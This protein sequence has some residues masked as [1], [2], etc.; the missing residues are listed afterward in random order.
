MKEADGC[1]LLL[2]RFT[3]AGY[4][5]A[6]D[7]HFREGA[8]E[9]DLD[10]WDEKARV[11]YEYIT[12][13]AGDQK[14]FDDKTLGEFERRMEKGDLYVLLVDEHDAVTESALDAAASGFLSELAKRGIGKGAK[15]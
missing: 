12:S 4:A 15:P 11:G 6:T 13:E 3:E 9:V 8:I 7:F 10:G 5:I 14:Q 2:S 1:A